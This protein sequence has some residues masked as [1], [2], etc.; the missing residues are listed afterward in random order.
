MNVERLG[1]HD[2]VEAVF[3]A[4]ELAAEL[5]GLGPEIVVGEELSDCDAIVTF[6]YGP[7]LLSAEW[8]HSIQ[9]GVDRFP[10]DE[11]ED[12]GVVLTNSTGIHGD[13]VGEMV[14]AYMIALARDLHGYIRNA[15]A[16]RWERPEWDRPFEITGE[17]VCVVGLGTLGM[18][19]ATR[20]DALGMSVGGVRRTAESVGPV[21]TVFPPSELKA[22]VDGARF[23]VAAVPLN[24]ETRGLIDGE[25]FEA[26]AE[27]A[28]LI[29]VARGP[30]VDESALIEALEAG[31]I[32]GAAL[33]VFE[34]EPLPDSSP[35]WERDDVIVTPHVAATVRSYYT[36]IAE[37][38]E[39]N[40]ERIAA[41][42]DLYNVVVDPRR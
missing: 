9:A 31:E 24:E 15:E 34:S 30:V 28:Y 33:D 4:E 39:E 35:L 19:V 20:A 41:S 2:S 11:F 36:D 32:A 14:T 26:M 29:N 12:E 27:D 5:S 40:L 18:G 3:P 16:K 10:F 22:A 25:V 21:E 38:V 42:E 37:I 6:T 1:I 13:S 23:V 17:A 8:V 7:S